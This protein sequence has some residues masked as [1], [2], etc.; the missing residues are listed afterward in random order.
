MEVWA[1]AS[2]EVEGWEIGAQLDEFSMPSTRKFATADEEAWI[3]RSLEGP[4][5]FINRCGY[6]CCA[7]QAAA[8]GSRGWLAQVPD[9]GIYLQGKGLNSKL[10]V[11]K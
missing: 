2:L 8:S 7:P 6:S 9:K 5:I 10:K 11:E 3:V 1:G 4:D